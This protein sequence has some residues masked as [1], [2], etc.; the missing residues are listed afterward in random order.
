M[1]WAKEH[2]EIGWIHWL[3]ID[4]NHFIKVEKSG[5]GDYFACV[6]TEG[7]PCGGEVEYFNDLRSAKR[8]AEQLTITGDWENYLL[9]VK[10]ES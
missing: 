4:S 9:T 1:Q 10:E 6:Y 7:D 8:F 3:Q 5:G 2:D